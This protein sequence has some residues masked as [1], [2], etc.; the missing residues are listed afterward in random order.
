M[1]GPRVGT[2]SNITSKQLKEVFLGKCTYIIKHVV[3]V[4]PSYMYEYIYCL[5]NM[6][7]RLLRSIKHNVSYERDVGVLI[8]PLKHL[9]TSWS[10][11]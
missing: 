9:R 8:L 10:S 11:I 5:F 6:Q 4:L 1:H 7:S 3:G 2:D